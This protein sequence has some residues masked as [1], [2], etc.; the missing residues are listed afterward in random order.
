MYFLLPETSAELENATS[1]MKQR[2]ITTLMFLFPLVEAIFLVMF[3][4]FFCGY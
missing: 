3:F 4:S 2:T 1:K